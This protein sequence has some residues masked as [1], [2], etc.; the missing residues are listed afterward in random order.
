MKKI[1]SSSAG[2]YAMWYLNRERQKPGHEKDPAQTDPATAVQLMQQSYRCSKWDD[3]YGIADWSIVSLDQSEF[4]HLVYLDSPWTKEEGLTVGDS[5]NYRL[6]GTVAKRAIDADYLGRDSAKSHRRYYREFELGLRLT[7][8]DR[9]MIRALKDNERK[10]NPDGSHYV[11]DGN[12]RCLPF[13]ILILE[14]K[15]R[16]EPVEAFL[17]NRV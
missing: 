15:L 8:H 17:A 1:R 3:G 13:M 9:I 5:P 6:L 4:E 7:G 10:G 2:E 14:G 12:G 11:Q 16:Y